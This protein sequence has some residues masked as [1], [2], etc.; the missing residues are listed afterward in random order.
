LEKQLWID[1]KRL[2]FLGDKNSFK[3]DENGKITL[4]N[5]KLVLSTI[6]GI[7]DKK[8]GSIQY[9]NVFT[10]N[11]GNYIENRKKENGWIKSVSYYIHPY[12]MD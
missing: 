6:L 9:A 5:M 7:K 3:F 1:L 4:G 11:K 10:A 8:P 12:G 2:N